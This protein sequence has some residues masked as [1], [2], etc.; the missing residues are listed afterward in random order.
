MLYLIYVDKRELRVL[1]TP[2]KE[3]CWQLQLSQLAAGQPL[4]GKS[5]NR[6]SQ[7]PSGSGYGSESSPESS[8]DAVNLAK[9]RQ[10]GRK[11]AK[12][13]SSVMVI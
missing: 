9:L 1:L 5:G 4:V 12:L 13:S 10:Q 6:N 8:L 2:E 3:E 11:K 7:A